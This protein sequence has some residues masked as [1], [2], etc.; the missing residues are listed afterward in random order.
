MEL[1]ATWFH[2]SMQGT[3][4][5]DSALHLRRSLIYQGIDRALRAEWQRRWTASE[6]GSA[7]REIIPTVGVAWTPMDIGGGNRLDLLETTRFITGHCHV[8]AFALP[9][10][11]EEWVMCPW[12]G[13]DFTREHLLWECRGLSQERRVFLRGI[14]SREFKSL[15]Q[16]VM[17]YGSRIGRFLRVARV[18]LGSLGV[19]RD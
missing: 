3:T 15:E 14:E 5:S 7:L 10:H 9:W 1:G 6:T 2:R 4:L 11:T 18:L 13:D 17:F 19:V 16:C 8:G 12:C